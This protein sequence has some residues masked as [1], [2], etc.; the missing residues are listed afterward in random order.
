MKDKIEKQTVAHLSVCAHIHT[1]I[2]HL[3]IHYTHYTTHTRSPPPIHAH[4]AETFISAWRFPGF[5]IRRET[6]AELL[7][8]TRWHQSLKGNHTLQDLVAAVK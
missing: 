7:A 1:H 3:H 2:P 5:P 6:S 4:T 8:V